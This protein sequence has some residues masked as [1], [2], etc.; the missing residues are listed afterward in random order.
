F[1]HPYGTQMIVIPPPPLKRRAKS[2]PSLWDENKIP[3][4][5]FA[6][7][8]VS[9]AEARCTRTDARMIFVLSFWI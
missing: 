4:R 8:S 5:T 6:I 1:K 3:T 2:I 9:V 7:T